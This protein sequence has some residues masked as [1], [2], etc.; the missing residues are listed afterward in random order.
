MD[1]VIPPIIPIPEV[2]PVTFFADWR[3]PR[4]Q[5]YCVPAVYHI[6]H[7]VIDIDIYVGKAR[8]A[9]DRVWQEL[10][11]WRKSEIWHKFLSS[12]EKDEWLKCIADWKVKILPFYPSNCL[13][14]GDNTGALDEDETL[15]IQRLEPVAN[16]N[17]CK[18]GRLPLIKERLAAFKELV[19]K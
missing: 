17:K 4:Y 18:P 8:R 19:L 10:F 11:S 3:N 15:F 2:L 5:L 7:P 12:E 14:Y 1:I 13:D 6:F 9:A 16:F